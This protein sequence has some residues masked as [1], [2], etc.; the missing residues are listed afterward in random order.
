MGAGRRQRGDFE[1]MKRLERA[2]RGFEVAAAGPHNVLTLPGIVI[3]NMGNCGKPD[4][5][6]LGK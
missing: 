3:L 2:K 4:F 5:K 1:D 6:E